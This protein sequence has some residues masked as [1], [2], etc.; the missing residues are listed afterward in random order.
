MTNDNN[1]HG[2]LLKA[3]QQLKDNT[4]RN[5]NL[6]GKSYRVRILQDSQQQAHGIVLVYRA[7]VHHNTH[8]DEFENQY[9]DFLNS[10]DSKIMELEEVHLT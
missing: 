1:T 8:L 4:K 6:M 2:I 9:L 10:T 3:L 7:A 5:Y